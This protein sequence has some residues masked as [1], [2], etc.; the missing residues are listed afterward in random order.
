MCMLL[1][2]KH[3][4]ST[5]KLQLI[6]KKEKKNENKKPTSTELLNLTTSNVVKQA[7]LL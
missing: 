4:E 7:E 2:P 1:P 6:E 3:F 5:I